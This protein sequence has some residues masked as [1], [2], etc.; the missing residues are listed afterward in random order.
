MYIDGNFHDLWRPSDDQ[1]MN[2]L[3]E[4]ERNIFNDKY[5]H[6]LELTI[7][8]SEIPNNLLLYCA[9]M[10]LGLKVNVSQKEM[11]YS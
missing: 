6:K 10:S 1:L 9:C 4:V 2:A 8:H 3:R 11:V 7:E 5:P